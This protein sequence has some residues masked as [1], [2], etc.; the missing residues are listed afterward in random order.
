MLDNIP[1]LII[2][3][4][5]L[6]FGIFILIA[7]PTTDTRDVIGVG[8]VITITQ[9]ITT[10]ELYYYYDKSQFGYQY[11]C[12]IPLIEEYNLIFSMGLDGCSLLFIILT[13]FILP[14]CILALS[15]STPKLRQFVLYLF[16]IELFLLLTF[17]TTNLFFFYIFFESLLIP[18][19]ILIGIWGARARKINAAYYFFLYTLFGSFFL[20][21]GILYLYTITE[22]TEYTVLSNTVLTR[23]EQIVLWI[24]F[25]LPFAIKVPMFPFHIWLPEAHV[26]APT[27]GSVILASLLLKLGG[28]G[29]LRFTLPMFPLG[30]EYFIEFVYVLATLGIIYSSL[31]A[32]IQSDLKKIIAYSSVAHMNFVVLGLFTGSYQGIDGAIYLML[33]H[34]IVSAAL[35]FCVGVLYDRFGTRS[36]KHYSGLVQTMPIMSTFFFLFTLGNMGFPGTS[37][38]IGEFLIIIGLVNHNMFILLFASTSIVLGA[39]YS[40]WL[41]NRICFGTLKVGKYVDLNRCEFYI[42]STLAS[43]ML[44]MGFTSK[45]VTDLTSI[46]IKQTIVRSTK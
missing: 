31:T 32:L 25:F 38:F 19:F 10:G 34:G 27:I 41:F 33:G 36:I 24:C 46:H 18:M 12:Q 2:Y 43:V 22:S 29:F 42:L 9:L 1:I 5:P 6:I 40:I 21:F 7:K 30:T 16:I 11:V 28:Y 17:L 26:E 44:I 14:L 4:I 8:L 45:F 3:L 23:E 13:V 37:N 15:E 35:F 39:I 20:L